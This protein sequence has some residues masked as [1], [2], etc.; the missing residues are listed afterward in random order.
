MLGGEL[1]VVE[2][3]LEQACRGRHAFHLEL[4][5]RAAHTCH[6]CRTVGGGNHELAHHRIELRGDGVA[7]HHA[8]IDADARA[9][10]PCELGQR[11]GA[12]RQILRR[13]L[14]GQPELEA[15]SAQRV[16]DGQ[17]AAVGDGELF[18]HQIKAADL[19]ADGVLH[20]QTGI[21]LQEI[22]LALF[23][24]HEFASAQTDVVDRFEKPA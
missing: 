9:G 18:S 5:Q 8:G 3:L 13:I 19:F 11:A 7:F 2:D 6:G 16:V 4:F 12:R 17:L 23:G 24:H 20:L 10:R 1:V 15:V 21:D 22:H 14:A